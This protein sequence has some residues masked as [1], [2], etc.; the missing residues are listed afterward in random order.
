MPEDTPDPH[1]T[2]NPCR[3]PCLDV[4]R[5]R[6]I[7]LVGDHAVHGYRGAH[8][9][10]PSPNLTP[11]HVYAALAYDSALREAVRWRPRVAAE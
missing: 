9:I 11:A 5:H 6:V 7:D 1:V 8:I 3:V 2:L 4:T 10:E